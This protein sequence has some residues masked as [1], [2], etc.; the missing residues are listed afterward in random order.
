MSEAT[1]IAFVGALNEDVLVPMAP[2]AGVQELVLASGFEFRNYTE[3]FVS[4]EVS[5]QILKLLSRQE[6]DVELG[7]SAFNSLRAAVPFAPHLRL[8]FVGVSGRRD[9][10]NPHADFCREMG[11][12]TDFLSLSSKPPARSISFTHDGDRTLLTSL[13]ANSEAAQLFSERLDLSLI[14]I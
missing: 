13:G 7:G 8:G 9:L 10:M 3:S 11:V 2:P 4:D 6:V 14:H 1:G 12:E 5:G